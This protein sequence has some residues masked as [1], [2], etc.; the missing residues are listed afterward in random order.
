MS[1]P[2][3]GQIEKTQAVLQD[4]RG[5]DAGNIFP[6][7]PDPQ[8]QIKKLE[9]EEFQLWSMY[10]L[11]LLALTAGLAAVM[12]PTSAQGTSRT[13]WQ[14]LPQLLAGLIALVILLNVYALQQRRRLRLTREELVAQLLRGETAEQLA[15]IDPLT[16]VYNR[17]YLDQV[18]VREAHRADRNQT[19]LSIAMIDIDDFKTVNTQYGHQKGDRILREVANLLVHTLRGSDTVIR[20]GGDEFLVIMPETNEEQASKAFARLAQIIHQWNVSPTADP[21]GFALSLSCGQA[22]YHP[23]G[24]LPDVIA[25]ADQHMYSMK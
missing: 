16:E 9:S 7:P 23:G 19:S 25:A 3:T 1:H 2:I 13:A 17:R 14:Y 15:L 21:P 22:T 11:I 12:A 24:N 8:Q 18:L 5:Q 10:A 4:T 6:R 20:Y